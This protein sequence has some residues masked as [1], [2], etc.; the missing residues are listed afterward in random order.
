VPDFAD[1][2]VR[3]RAVGDP[4]EVTDGPVG[5]LSLRAVRAADMSVG[6]RRL[7]H[8]VDRFRERAVHVIDRFIG[9]SHD[10]GVV[11]QVKRL[12]LSHSQ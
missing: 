6:L 10:V 3:F 5:K 12:V 7:P 8:A 1:G 4:A 11:L 2:T 9:D